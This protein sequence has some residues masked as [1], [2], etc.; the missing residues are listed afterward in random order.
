MEKAVKI[1]PANNHGYAWYYREKRVNCIEECRRKPLEFT[2][3]LLN[4]WRLDL[5]A[6]RDVS[7]GG[8]LAGCP[9]SIKIG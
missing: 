6:L 3:T 9:V 5:S 7:E 8:K 4:K 2:V 1:A